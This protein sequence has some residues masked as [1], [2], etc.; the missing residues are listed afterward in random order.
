MPT[1]AMGTSAGA[2]RTGA[3]AGAGRGA[4]R[5]VGATAAG[6]GAP[7]RWRASALTD[8]CANATVA[9]TLRPSAVDSSAR[10]ATAPTESRPRLTK[11]SPVRTLDGATPRRAARRVTSHASRDVSDDSSLL[12]GNGFDSTATAFIL[13]ARRTEVQ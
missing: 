13:P 1:I 4:L 5:G 10:S 9:G 8:G 3:G 12:V 7:A 6:V 2:A 11:L